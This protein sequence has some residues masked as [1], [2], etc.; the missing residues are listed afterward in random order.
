[1]Y[2]PLGIFC[3]CTAQF[4][5]KLVGKPEEYFFMR[6]SSFVSDA[7]RGLE[8]IIKYV[9]SLLYFWIIHTLKLIR[10]YLVL[11]ER[12]IENNDMDAS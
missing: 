4:V 5:S 9:P 11:I 12:S 7:E 3:G 10:T 6:R 2:Q 1:M 8:A